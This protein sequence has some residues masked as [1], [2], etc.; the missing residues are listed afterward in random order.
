MLSAAIS[1]PVFLS[2]YLLSLIGIL[3]F[4]P[5]ASSNQSLARFKLVFTVQVAGLT[6]FFLIFGGYSIDAWRYLTRFTHNP[7]GFEEEWLFWVVG[8]TLSDIF[9]N[10]WPIK[11]LSV[12]AVFLWILAIVRIIGFKKKEILVVG[13]ALLPLMPAFF[14]TMGN[15]VR[16]GLASV[17][18][19][20]AIV[21]LLSQRRW[22]FGML[23]IVG[24]LV[25]QMSFVFV[26]AGMAM[27]IS[28][29][30]LWVF[31]IFAPFASFFGASFLQL[32]G[33]DLADYVRYAYRQ[34]GQLHYFKFA[35]YFLASVGLLVFSSIRVV[36][37]RLLLLINVFVVTVSC[38]S[39]L[40]RYEVPF[41]RILL[42]ADVLLPIIIA[43]V[44]AEL[45]LGARTKQVLW[46]GVLCAGLLLW[47]SG[48]V[49]RTLTAGLAHVEDGRIES[50]QIPD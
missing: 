4:S 21:Y 25:H 18:V 38:A 27:R 48:A 20:H 2:C 30:A 32:W 41:E 33:I 45:T 36:P 31:L 15:A 12:L 35:V 50:Y 13:L 10:P 37:K 44:L 9:P 34:D 47:T 26:I 1:S 42:Y 6:A 46:G 19:L 11:I 24:L 3:F 49:N 40:L 16:Q 43:M 22:Q 5:I 29:K 39:L 17:I 23:S 14:F 8:H 28:R 7:F